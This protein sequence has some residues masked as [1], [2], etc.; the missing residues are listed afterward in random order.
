MLL[1]AVLAAALVLRSPAASEASAPHPVSSQTSPSGPQSDCVLEWRVQATDVVSDDTGLISVKAFATNDTWAGGYFTGAWPGHAPL[2]E[3]WDGS[4]WS[5]VATPALTWTNTRIDSIDGTG[6]NDVWAVGKANEPETTT[7]PL[8]LHYDGSNWS[9]V[10]GPVVTGTWA[11]LDAVTAIAPDDVWVVGSIAGVS[12]RDQQ[13]Y[14][15]HWDGEE[16]TVFDSPTGDGDSSHLSAVDAISANDVWAVGYDRD[17]KGNYV[18]P[19][20]VHWDGSTW[21]AVPNPSYTTGAH[22]LNG[23]KA[24]AANDVWAVGREDNMA[25]IEH[26]DGSTWTK[27]AATGPDAP[28]YALIQIDG[29]APDDLWAVGGVTYEDDPAHSRPLL[30]HYDG[31]TW[32]VAPNDLNEYY[33]FYPLSDV[34]VLSNYEAWATGVTAVNDHLQPLMLRYSGPFT[35]AGAGTPFYDYIMCLA[36]R[37]VLGGYS[38]AANC[39]ETGPPCFRPNDD[40]TRG[41]AAKI[42]SNAAGYSEDIP[43]SRQSFVDVPPSSPFWLYIERMHEH[44]TIGGYPCGEDEEPCPGNYYRPGARLTRGQLAK[45]ATSTAGFSDTPGGQTFNDVPEDAPFYLYIERAYAHGIISGYA[46]GNPGEDCPGAYF[47]PALNVTRGQA[48]KIVAGTFFPNCQMP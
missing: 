39:P 44:G 48:A 6:P 13:P 40:I 34:S 32:S 16:W 28:W 29:A 12:Y 24:L 22:E 21:S 3:H 9:I 26:W 19:L 23:L 36:C 38:D 46:C 25:L 45:I 27:V 14:I 15:A 4:S 33:Y 42:I 10:P 11:G 31:S 41:Q 43:A 5:V 2:L 18:T 37:N 17:V 30:M 7:Q 20:I 1:L 8:I 47:R 35:D